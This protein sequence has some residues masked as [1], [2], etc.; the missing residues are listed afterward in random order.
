MRTT[1][2]IVVV[3]FFL[4]VALGGCQSSPKKSPD[5]VELRT[6]SAPL[7]NN[8]GDLHWPMTTKDKL[9]QRYFDQ[10]VT[11]AY[12]FN[13]PEAVRSFRAAQSLDADFAMAYWGEAYVLGPNINAAMKDEDVPVAFAAMQ[14]AITLKPKVSAKEQALI[15][16]MAARYGAQPVKDR[17]SLDAAYANAMRH[18]ARQFADDMHVQTIFAE[19]LMDLTPWDYWRGGLPH[20]GTKEIVATLERVLATEPDN[21]GAIHFYIHAVEAGPTP[22]KAE[23]HADRLPHL[24]K[25]AGHLVHMPAHIHVNVGRYY[26]AVVANQLA[27]RADE[28]YIASCK[29]QGFY[30]ALY[31]SHNLH[32]LWFAGHMAGC[33]KLSI[34]AAMKTHG[35]LCCGPVAAAAPEMQVLRPVRIQALARFGKWDQVLKEEKPAADAPFD[36]AAWHAATGIALVR[37]GKLDEAKKHSAAL[38][39]L[40]PGEPIKAMELPSFPGQRIV[41]MHHLVLDAEVKTAGG[42]RDAGIASFAEAVKVQD[43]LPYMEPPWYYYPVRQSLGWALIEAGKPAEAEAVYREDLKRNRK[44]GWSLFGLMKALEAQKK[45]DEAKQVEAQFKE[46]WKHADVKL[47]ASRF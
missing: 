22:E 28:R 46:A 7:F 9:A 29:V 31:Y 10:G 32:F 8:L 27:S 30:P 37:T 33:S 43:T 1:V 19:A 3:A 40:V 34:D 42:D 11:L 15:D 13:H 16:A 17:A 47:T 38:A 2:R 39:A 36:L 5:M 24:C 21:I 45:S 18:V 41:R 26:D 35:H 4:L 44:N 14:K 25:G 12:A 20:D 23:A 6:G